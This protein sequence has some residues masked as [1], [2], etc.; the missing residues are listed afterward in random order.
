MMRLAAAPAIVLLLA[1]CGT[2]DPDSVPVAAPTPSQAKDSRVEELQLLVGEMADRL[3]VMNSRMQR[4]ETELAEVPRGVQPAAPAPARVSA[5]AA[6]R[7][8]AQPAPA[9]STGSLPLDYRAALE[10]F[11]RGQ[12][13]RARSAFQEV[14][15]REPGGDLADNALY[16]IGETYFAAGD[17]HEAIRYYSRVA[18]EYGDQN[19][20]PDAM[21]KIG[22]SYERL[23]DLSL[24]RRA[25]E[26]LI[27]RF[28]YA[29]PADSAKNALQRI[30]Y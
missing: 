25:Y 19:K 23:G 3:E 5:P 15:D 9:R 14:F 16:W 1:A 6:V 10:L 24:A 22:M 27:R 30:K 28:P 12:H 20:A 8:A 2:A 17:Y 11:G 18:D 21:F 29:T 13:E 26:N 7:P 4:L